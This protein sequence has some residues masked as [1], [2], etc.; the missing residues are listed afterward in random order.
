MRL[1]QTLVDCDK[2]YAESTLPS[3]LRE[4]YDG[5]LHFRT[6]PTARP[7]VISNF[8]STLDGVVSYEI[9]GK[10][11]GSTIS[12][13]DPGDRFI[14]GLLRASADAIIVG[15]RTLQDVSAKGL[16]SPEYVYPDAKRLYTEY[17]VNT[18]HKPEYPLL[19]IVS[20]SGQ[21]E[22]E[23]AIFH[24]PAMRTL[25][26]T[27]SA[28]RDELTRRGAVALSSVEICALN[29]SDG[30]IAPRAILQLLQSQFGIKTLLHEGGPTLFGQFL[31]ADAVDE[32]F[33]TLSPQIAGR[34]C[35]TTRPAVVQG[36]AFA[37][38][39]APRFQ[40]LSVK[41]KAAYLYLRYR[42]T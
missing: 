23:R 11:G 41:E 36:V 18:L 7:F 31:A 16:W 8:V 39:S 12:A 19:V 4:L 3:E 25:V 21:L 5:D 2:E 30:S 24:A 1:V 6:P 42:R 34:K 13:S 17:R 29:S 9:K 22:L 28:G 15:A 32:L 10:S 40:M 20:G 33:L 35:D 38:D 27:T 26:I 37:P 14:M